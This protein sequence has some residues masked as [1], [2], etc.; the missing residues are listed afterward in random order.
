MRRLR[1]NVN[2]V[3]GPKLLANAA[4]D[5]RPAH[6]THGRGFRAGHHSAYHRSPFPDTITIKSASA[7]CNSATPEPSRCAAMARFG[8]KAT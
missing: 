2:N 3:A 6:L 5:G 7:S 4:V 1:W 8:A